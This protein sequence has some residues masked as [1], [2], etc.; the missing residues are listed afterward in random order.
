MKSMTQRVAEFCRR[1]NGAVSSEVAEHFN[2]HDSE[3]RYL[4]RTIR[5]AARYSTVETADANR[6]RVRVTGIKK[7]VRHVVP[8]IAK[9]ITTGEEYKFESVADA[10]I[11]GGFCASSIRKCLTGDRHKHAGYYWKRA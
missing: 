5:K 9:N 2:I 8:V 6:I 10:E 3:A 7:I 1:P 4:L 11:R